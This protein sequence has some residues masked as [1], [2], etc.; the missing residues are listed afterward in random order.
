MII[1]MRKDAGKEVIERVRSEVRQAKL[2]PVV[3]SGVERTVIAVIGE[4]TLEKAAL[5]DH[6]TALAGVERVNAI[7]KPYKLSS[8]DYHPENLV[9]KVREIEIGGP[10]VII[11]AGPCAVETREQTIEA[12]KAVKEA[13]AK[14]LRGGA[15]RKPRTFPNS[16][17][18]LGEEG[19]KILAEAREVTGL[20]IITEVMSPEKV[21]MIAGYADILQIGA[22][23][24]QNFDLL[25]AVGRQS[26]PV[27]LKRGPA[28]KIK[29][30]LGAVDYILSQGNP[31]VILCERGVVKF[32]DDEMMRHLTD[33]N[34]IPILKRESYLPVFL[35]PSHATGKRDLI[36][37]VSMAGIAAGADGLMIEV[38]IHPDQARSDAA[39]QLWP[40]QFAEIMPKFKAIALANGRIMN[41]GP[42]F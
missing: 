33:I 18:G 39:Q 30:Y 22:R 28:L 2:K 25:E 21:E 1:I 11:I 15:F 3:N 38:H 42:R 31:N 6:F 36:E 23:N 37:S 13:G 9:I 16:F 5:M 20:P 26:K 14:I 27:F 40:E 10:E 34:A 29:E 17:Q 32:D 12:A 4:I 41:L 8:R 19:L 24:S 7:S 35:D